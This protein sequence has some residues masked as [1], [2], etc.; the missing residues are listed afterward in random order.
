[1]GAKP[2]GAAQLW[3]CRLHLGWARPS[4]WRAQWHL[5]S[6]GRWPRIWLTGYEN[7]S[8]VQRKVSMSTWALS[9]QPGASVISETMATSAAGIKT[10]TIP[11]GACNQLAL[12]H[13]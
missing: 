2:V 12:Q 11:G 5:W 9:L 7:D 6:S 4:L 3:K 1:M 13:L 10:A 8:S